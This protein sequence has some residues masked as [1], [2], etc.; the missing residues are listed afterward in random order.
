MK[1]ASNLPSVSK[2]PKKDIPADLFKEIAM[3]IAKEVV[4]Y[5]SRMYPKAIEATSST[6][7]LSLRNCIYNEIMEAIKVNDE[8]KI[9]ARLKFN[10]GFRRHMN[11]LA[12]AGNMQ[13]LEAAINEYKPEWEN[14]LKE[15]GL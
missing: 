7:K 4:H 1:I 8:G 14:Y 12:R 6:F 11:R 3:D 13:E 9:V 10:E 5:V 2:K 15:M